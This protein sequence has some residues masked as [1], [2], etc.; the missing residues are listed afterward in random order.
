LSD[1]NNVLGNY[2]NTLCIGVDKEYTISGQHTNDGV[3]RGLRNLDGTG[4]LVGITSIGSVQGYY[5]QD[6]ERAPMPGELYYRGI[7]VADIVE[8][9]TQAK[10]FGYEEVAYLLLMGRLPN[11]EQ[12]RYF[13][14]VLSKSHQLPTCFAEDVIL[15]SPS[16]DVM[17]M[18]SRSVLAL[19]AYD[20]FPED[21][22]IE[23]LMRQSIELIARFPSII[24]SAY[25]I[26]RHR[27]DG[28]TLYI[29]IPKEHLTLSENFLRMLRRNKTFTMEEALLL[30]LM[31]ILHAEHGGGNNSSFVC[32]ALSSSGTDTYG[33]ISGAIN[34]LKGPLHGG[35][36]AKVIE[37]LQDIRNNVSDICDENEVASHLEKL[38][39]KKAGDR[40]GKIYGLGHAVYTMSDPRAV[41]IK[42]YARDLAEKKGRLKEFEFI[43]SVERLGLKKVSERKN[44]TLPQCANVDLYSGFVYGLLDIPE[45]LFTP[46]FALARIT[47][48]CAHRIEEVLTCNRIMRPAYRASVKKLPYVPASERG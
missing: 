23:N 19:Y 6:G 32:R 9:H 41:M 34:S 48:W 7:N 40:S 17:N 39:D 3:K 30:D 20:Q 18:L 5:V 28:K 42:K 4:V 44:L 2:I 21:N 47:G 11:E 27:H 38:L 12:Y 43:E 35:A 46:L 10:T 26:K 29:H 36:N 24:A 16:K 8:A 14:T 13:K 37:M 15:R 1:Q 45:E 31:L 22:S 33:A 25:A